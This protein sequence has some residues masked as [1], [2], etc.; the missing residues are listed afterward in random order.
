MTKLRSGPPCECC[1]AIPVVKSSIPQKSGM[2]RRYYVCGC[3]NR[4]SLIEEKNRPGL[5]HHRLTLDLPILTEWR[6]YPFVQT[7]QWR[8]L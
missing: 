2:V 7:A 8:P 3:G 6:P 1:G 5:R 4:F